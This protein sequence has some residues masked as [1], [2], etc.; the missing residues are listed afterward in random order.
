[1]DDGDGLGLR[2][3]ARTRLRHREA[4]LV[5]VLDGVSKRALVLLAAAACGEQGDETGRRRARPIIADAEPG[6]P[7]V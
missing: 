2:V 7:G 6:P 4:V 1:M 5:Q 3:A